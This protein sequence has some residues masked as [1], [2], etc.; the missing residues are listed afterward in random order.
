VGSQFSEKQKT[1]WSSNNN[2][3]NSGSVVVFFGSKNPVTMEAHAKD[4]E[5]NEED[6]AAVLADEAVEEEE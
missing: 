5:S 3:K 6:N 2:N 4:K 1:S